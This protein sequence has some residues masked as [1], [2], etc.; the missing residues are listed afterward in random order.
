LFQFDEILADID[1]AI[2]EFGETVVNMLT[3]LSH[4]ET[5]GLGE[6]MALNL[7]LNNV[8]K[9][10]FLQKIPLEQVRSSVDIEIARKHIRDVHMMLLDKLYTYWDTWC[11]DK[12][13]VTQYR[14][15]YKNYEFIVI[16]DEMNKNIEDA[17]ELMR[18][19]NVSDNVV[20]LDFD[21]KRIALTDF[22]N[23]LVSNTPMPNELLIDFQLKSFEA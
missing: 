2:R 5:G 8:Y 11:S 4:G 20:D 16:L 15:K 19:L 10:V 12:D 21:P 23:H 13:I 22:V 1:K 17:E 7:Y 14:L 9:T 6:L 18:S 3:I